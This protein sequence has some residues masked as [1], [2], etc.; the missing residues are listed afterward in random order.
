[1]RIV[2]IF[3]LSLLAFS[4][5]APV[6]FAD[7]DYQCLNECTSNSSGS[8]S[9][10]TPAVCLKSCTYAPSGTSKARTK[11]KKKAARNPYNQFS[12]QYVGDGIFL[13]DSHKERQLP[14]KNY[15]CL[16]SCLQGGLQYGYCQEHCT[17]H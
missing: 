12:D 1:M 11:L 2:S 13:S 5:T 6:A 9:K 3:I 7:T 10:I 14:E 16:N 17:P 8:G 15:Q 4:A